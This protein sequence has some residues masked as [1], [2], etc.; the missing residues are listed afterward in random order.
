[1]GKSRYIVLSTDANACGYSILR[2][3]LMRWRDNQDGENQD[4]AK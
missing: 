4:K 2:K 3:M 1:M